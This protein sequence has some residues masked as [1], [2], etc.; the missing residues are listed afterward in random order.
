MVRLA[1]L[2]LPKKNIYF[3]IRIFV[4]DSIRKQNVLKS[5]F[6]TK[7]KQTKLI[8]SKIEQVKNI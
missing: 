6:G 5:Y 8:L 2:I 1:I 7:T 4:N 3:N